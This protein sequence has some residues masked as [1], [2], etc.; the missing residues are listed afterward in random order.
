MRAMKA[1]CVWHA[2]VCDVRPARSLTQA[3]SPRERA[4]GTG[5][6]QSCPIQGCLRNE[7]AGFLD[8]YEKGEMCDFSREARHCIA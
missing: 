7:V 1:V 6:R 5:A 8:S 2:Y 3:P 4:L